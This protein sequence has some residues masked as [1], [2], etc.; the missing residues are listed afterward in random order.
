MKAEN[1]HN[2]SYLCRFEGAKLIQLIIFATN[3][4]TKTRPVTERDIF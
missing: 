4:G 2:C 1:V 3:N